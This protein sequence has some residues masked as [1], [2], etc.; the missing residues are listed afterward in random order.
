MLTADTSKLPISA[1]YSGVNINRTCSYLLLPV[2][3]APFVNAWNM[4]ASSGSGECPILMV[5]VSSS[6]SWVVIQL[7]CVLIQTPRNNE[8]VNF[9]GFM[10]D[11][12]KLS[13]ASGQL[14]PVAQLRERP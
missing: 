10:P 11:P 13:T 7:K 6:H 4:K 5:T 3:I 12:S 1:L 8:M 9:A 2:S 14:G